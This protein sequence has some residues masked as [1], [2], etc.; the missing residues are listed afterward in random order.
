MTE[1]REESTETRRGNLPLCA[2]ICESVLLFGGR[3]LLQVPHLERVVL[4]GGDEDG[5]DGV[6]RQS[7]DAVEVAPQGELGVPRLSHGV[8]VVADLRGDGGGRLV[9]AARIRKTS[10]RRLGE[11]FGNWDDA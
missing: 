2:G 10:G 6:E 3:R 7:A 5:L 4:R 8:R 11:R 9:S 1:H